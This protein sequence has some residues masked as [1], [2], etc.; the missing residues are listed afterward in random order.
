MHIGRGYNAPG[1]VHGHVFLVTRVTHP[2]VTLDKEI[3]TLPILVGVG[4]VAH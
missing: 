2:F 3:A 4:G 1:F